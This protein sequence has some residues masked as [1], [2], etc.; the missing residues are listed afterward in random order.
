MN[1]I[2][3]RDEFGLTHHGGALALVTHPWCALGL[4]VVVLMCLH[5]FANA[6]TEPAEGKDNDAVKLV[7]IPGG[8][9]KR[10][11]LSAKAAERLGIETGTIR[12]D[13]V[14]RE[15]MVGGTV[16]SPTDAPPEQKVMSRGSF[17]GF[18]LGA[19]SPAPQ[20]AA[21]ASQ[22][23]ASAELTPI[24]REVWVRVTLSPGEYER[25][26]KDQVA[27]IEQLQ[28]R[29]KLEREL[30]AQPVSM[31]PIEDVKRSMLTLHYALPGKDHGLGLYQRVRVGLPL[32]GSNG[33]ETVVPYRAVYYDAQGAPW[34]YVTSRPL[35]FERQRVVVDRVVGDLA[36]L[37]D[38]PPVGTKVV[39]VGAALLYG[40]EIFGK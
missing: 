38:G 21:P 18:A 15:Q 22:P 8:T 14:V 17:A 19:M 26:A 16:I 20:P 39:T 31:Q 10:V 34:V 5:T 3:R 24:D 9:T 37:T 36:V 4:L 33:P 6:A 7:S 27:R 28:T 1:G 13:T 12:K 32:L 29:E 11:T 30:V 25:L 40:A 23:A 2:F 35:A